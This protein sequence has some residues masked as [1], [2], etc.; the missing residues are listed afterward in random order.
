MKHYLIRTLSTVAITSIALLS[1]SVVCHA[2]ESAPAVDTS[3]WRLS[4]DGALSATQSSYSDNWQGGELGSFNWTFTSNSSAEKQISSKL[5]WSNSL[6]LSFGLTYSQTRLVDGSPHWQRPEKNT[7]LIDLESVARVTLHG[8]VDPYFAGRL[9]TELYDASVR[10]VRRYLSPATIT[11]SGGVLRLFADGS[12]SESKYKVTLKSRFGFGLRQTITSVITDTAAGVTKSV[13]D[14]DGGLESV[15]D[16]SIEA[17]KDIK[18][19]GKLTLF[20]SLFFSG[21]DI[22]SNDDWKAL[23]VNWEHILTAQI[24]KYVQTSLYVQLLF[25]K[26]L[27]SGVRFKQTMGMGVAVNVL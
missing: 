25:D 5:T 16:L 13:T 9:Q 3:G 7:D 4:L 22:A 15:T 21:S 17:G 19:T 24:T 27:D 18:Y 26:Q 8:F 6:K 14:K 23:D 11:E 12:K 20:K 2:Q 1:F 10:S